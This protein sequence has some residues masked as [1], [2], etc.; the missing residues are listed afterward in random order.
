MPKLP[1]TPLPAFAQEM[2]PEQGMPKMP[3]LPNWEVRPSAPVVQKAYVETRFDELYA[4]R[5]AG[6]KVGLD[7]VEKMLRAKLAP[8]R[9][10]ETIPFK[11]LWRVYKSI[12]RNLQ[13]AEL[14]VNF[15]CETWFSQPNPYDDYTQMYQRA[16]ESGRMVLRNTDQNDADLR[17]FADNM[18]TFP[19]SWQNGASAQSQRG[20]APSLKPGRQSPERIQK[21]MDTGDLTPIHKGDALPAFLAGNPHFNPHTKQVFLAL[22][23]GRRRHGSAFNYGYSYFV[24]KSKLKPQCFYY[25]QDT[26]M[27]AS[28]GVDAGAV[29]VLYDNL[30]AL[31]DAGGNSFL[32]QD[33]FTSCYEGQILDDLPPEDSK[34]CKY[35]LIE[36]HRFG[37]LSFSKHVD[38]MVIS[39]TGLS[40]IN[41]WPTIVANASAFAQRNG[42]QL[43][44]IE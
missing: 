1:K 21:Q 40:D 14:T 32:Q 42:I 28:K 35:Y 39:K 24:A 38:H 43:F 44:E 15:K 7:V 5:L 23:Y 27:R 18:V 26:F 3:N 34:L 17:A 13:A 29:Q 30:G 9:Q 10:H 16:V 2:I 6:R 36:A 33:L 25:A 11:E 4:D 22:N 37:P 12:E 20:Q 31:L 19:K 41:L 8:K